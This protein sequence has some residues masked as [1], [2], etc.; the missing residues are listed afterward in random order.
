[1]I[2]PLWVG[3]YSSMGYASYLI[4]RDGGG[5]EGKAVVP[6]AL[7]GSQLAL[8]WMWA[9]TFFDCKS[10]RMVSGCFHIRVKIPAYIFRKPIRK[11]C[12]SSV[13][14]IN[15]SEKILII[16]SKANSCLQALADL[17]LLDCTVAACIHQYYP[18]N[19]NAAY[20]MIPYFMW[21]LLRT[22]LN[23]SIWRL[24]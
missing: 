5:L 24:N 9:P 1:M 18:I 3:L 15:A 12:W 13:M 16:L 8:N 17:L 23:F 22:A 2:E 20:M 10:I 14:I 21:M 4:Y 6:L 19:K 11:A 7:Y